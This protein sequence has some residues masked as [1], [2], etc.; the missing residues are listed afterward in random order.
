M[1]P[2]YDAIYLSPH[3]DDGALSCGGQIFLQTRT[4]ADV[5]VVTVAAGAP[6]SRQRSAFAEYLHEKW[7]LSDSE[8]ITARRVEDETAYRSLGA[9]WLH[10]SLPDAIYRVHRD[11]G[12]PLYTSNEAIFGALDPAEAPLVA[13]LAQQIRELPR[14]NRIVAPLTVGNHVDHQLTRRAAE[15]AIPAGLVYYE[16][17]PYVQREPETLAQLLQPPD[18]WEAERIPLPPEAVDAR[19]RAV[20]AYR[21]QIPMLF[22]TESELETKLRAQV[23]ATGGER[24]WRRRMD[25]PSD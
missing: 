17:Y 23:A 1:K 2:F 22:N 9:D 24:L 12:A 10:W 13:D 4:G 14:A 11:T 5:L 6:R 16:D 25:T 7:G 18:A 15:G 20:L 8:A 3:L 21:S 19:L